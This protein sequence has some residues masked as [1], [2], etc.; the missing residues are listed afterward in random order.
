MKTLL[1][2]NDPPD[3]TERSFFGLRLAMALLARGCGRRL[4]D[5]GGLQDPALGQ[6]PGAGGAQHHP[7][8][9]AIP[10]HG[11]G[12]GRGVGAAQPRSGPPLD[13]STAGGHCHGSSHW[14]QHVLAHAVPALWCLHR[15][16]HANLDYGLTTGARFHARSRPVL[17]SILSANW[18]TTAMEPEATGR[19]NKVSNPK[20]PL[21]HIHASDTCE[22]NLGYAPP[23]R[24]QT[25]HRI[26]LG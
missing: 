23:W 22:Y 1:I 12:R 20:M 14:L 18:R 4:A 3:G 10:G 9:P 7:A 2:L 15:V 19:F 17:D 6:Q 26:R 21:R 13:C 25:K 8:S 5:P 11:R 16:H 24:Q